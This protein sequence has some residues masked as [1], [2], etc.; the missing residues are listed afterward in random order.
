MKTASVLLSVGFAACL[1]S[2]FLQAA[3]EPFYQQ[4]KE[5]EAEYGF[6]AASSPNGIFYPGEPARISLVVPA[7]PKSSLAGGTLELVSVHTRRQ[8]PGEKG[9]F[10][11]SAKPRLV[12]TPPIRVPLDLT[13]AKNG[14]LDVRVP[15]PETF[16]SYALTLIRADGSRTRLGNLLRVLKPTPRKAAIPHLMSGKE[17][18]IG[19]PA[20]QERLGVT[21]IRTEL[22]WGQDHKA[23]RDVHE[24]ARHGIKVMVTTGVHPESKIPYRLGGVCAPKDDAE[25]GKWVEEFVRKHYTDGKTGLWGLENFNEPW[26]PNGISGWGSDSQRYRQI[27]KTLYQSAKRANPGITI[28]GTSSIMNTEDKFLSEGDGGDLMQ[29]VDI[30]T[31]HYVQPKGAYGARMAI[32][33]KKLTG[34]TETWG[35]GSEVLYHQF[36]AQFLA[37]GNTFLSPVQFGHFAGSVWS[38]KVTQG[39]RNWDARFYNANSV[40]MAMATWNALVQDRPFTG[41]AFKDHLPFVFQFGDDQDAQLVLIGRLMALQTERARDVVWPQHAF[42]P[43]GTLTLADPKREIEVRDCAGNPAPRDADGGYTLALSPTPWFVRSPDARTAKEAI[44]AGTMTGL[45]HVEILPGTL[46][47]VPTANKPAPLTVRLHNLRN[48]PVAGT[49]TV[50]TL[51]EQTPFTSSQP[52]EIATGATVAVRVLIAARYEGGLPLRFS[53]DIGGAIETWDEVVPCTGVVRTPISGLSDPAWATVPTVVVMRAE[54]S[55]AGNEIDKIWK[56]FLFADTTPDKLP[57]K[58]ADLQVAWDDAGL[59]IRG[60]L[61]ADKLGQRPRLETRDDEA[62]FYGAKDDATLLA[63]EAWQD[64]FKPFNERGTERAKW[65]PTTHPNSKALWV[66]FE[67]ASQNPAWPDFIA[68]LEKNASAKQFVTSGVAQRFFDARKTNPAASLADAGS[69]YRP[70]RDFLNELPFWGDS[71]VVAIDFD[72]AEERFQRLHDLP[73][74]PW[75]LP[76]GFMAVPDTDYEYSAYLCDDGK[77][78]LWCLLAP[79]VPRYHYFPRH[80]RGP[81]GQYPVKDGAVEVRRGGYRN[82][83]F[84]RL[85]WAQLGFAAPPKPGQDFA[86]TCKWNADGGVEFGGNYAATKSNGLTLHPYWHAPSSNTVRWT[87]LP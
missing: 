86:L 41:M 17:W 35:G 31:D 3:E 32:K 79:G 64:F 74:L 83:Y 82:V 34:E 8:T 67:K 25:F 71:F 76:D 72:K 54:G 11:D 33:W 81:K 62:F 2:P 22:H 15:L 45:R 85:T 19:E 60:S 37:V 43:D 14:S 29:Y 1:F 10:N 48:A 39:D 24:Y 51:T 44:R 57:A 42:A 46:P 26:E 75:S 80:T 73:Q 63:M 20:L 5:R 12:G 36:M 52:V 40:G 50:S 77:P 7:E 16:G 55:A 6:Y 23:D 49:L 87:L 53:V 27:Q 66:A 78:E 13:Q 61:K 47:F 21:L 9:F 58:R 56:P 4:P 18:D 30:L 68:Y 84:M 69:V 28:L 65:D 38:T 59:S 70:G